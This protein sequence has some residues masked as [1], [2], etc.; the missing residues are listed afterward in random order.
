M[1]YKERALQALFK[2][3]ETQP[4]NQQ[5]AGARQLKEQSGDRKAEREGVEARKSPKFINIY[6]LTGADPSE[7]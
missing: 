1:F 4:V 7:T 2:N 6:K 3:N 5:S